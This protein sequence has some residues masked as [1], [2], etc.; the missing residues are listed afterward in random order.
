MERELE[1]TAW[2]LQNVTHVLFE[3]VRRVSLVLERE[4]VVVDGVTTIR[5]GW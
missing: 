4:A 1:L 3:A 5:G 2:A